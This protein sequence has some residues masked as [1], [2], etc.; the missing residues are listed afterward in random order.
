MRTTTKW[1]FCLKTPLL[2]LRKRD[3]ELRGDQGMERK[4]NSLSKSTLGEESFADIFDQ[5]LDGRLE[6]SLDNHAELIVSRKVKEE[7]EEDL[8][9]IFK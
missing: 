8:G 9:F 1:K 3:E 5:H 4:I 7:A 2:F 6:L